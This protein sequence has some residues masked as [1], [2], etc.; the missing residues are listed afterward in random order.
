M[1]ERSERQEGIQAR[2]SV[3]SEP[4]FHILHL[5]RVGRDA[6]IDASHHEQR[7]YSFVLPLI[8]LECGTI[9]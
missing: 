2:I 5:V 7:W 1:K 4:Q 9:F 3:G 8:M 6:R